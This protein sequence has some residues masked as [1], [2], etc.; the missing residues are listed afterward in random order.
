MSQIDRER[1]GGRERRTV[2]DLKDK[3]TE[4]L[5]GRKCLR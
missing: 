4:E 2:R 3:E 1:F 5:R